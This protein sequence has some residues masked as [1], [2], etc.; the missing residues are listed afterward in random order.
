MASVPAQLVHRE[1][2]N[3]VNRYQVGNRVVVCD[4]DS[5][6]SGQQGTVYKAYTQFADDPD[7][8]AM[9]VVRMDDGTLYWSCWPEAELIMVDSNA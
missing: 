3:N 1:Q 8:G 5:L 9:Y 4:E 2:E 6:W 7:V